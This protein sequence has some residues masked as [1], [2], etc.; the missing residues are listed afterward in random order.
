MLPAY[1]TI[2]QDVLATVNDL[3]LQILR[4]MLQKLVKNLEGLVNDKNSPIL[5]EF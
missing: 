1:K 3:E 2:T 4:E 5:M